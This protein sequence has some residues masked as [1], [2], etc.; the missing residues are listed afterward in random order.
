MALLGRKETANVVKLLRHGG[1]ITFV[2]SQ[3][4]S[5]EN[6]KWRIRSAE[7]DKKLVQ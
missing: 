5:Q 7:N 6:K 3:A 1:C 2:C 4:I